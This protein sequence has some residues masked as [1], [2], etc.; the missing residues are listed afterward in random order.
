MEK[1]NRKNTKISNLDNAIAI[2][3]YVTKTKSIPDK[4]PQITRKTLNKRWKKKK[5]KVE[6][7]CPGPYPLL[8]I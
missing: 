4:Y 7:S 6:L 1:I 8:L 5:D 3:I 2:K